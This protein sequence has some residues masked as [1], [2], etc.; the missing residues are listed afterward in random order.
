MRLSYRVVALA[1]GDMVWGEEVEFVFPD[2]KRQNLFADLCKT[3]KAP[4]FLAYRYSKLVENDY[5]DKPDYVI[6]ALPSL[7][8]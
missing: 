6:P 1:R 3:G 5:F 4:W 2:E 7:N 8:R